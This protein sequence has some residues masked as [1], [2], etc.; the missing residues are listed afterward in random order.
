MTGYANFT[1]SNLKKC[2]AGTPFAA[3][4]S[5][6]H[7]LGKPHDLPKAAHLQTK[8]GAHFTTKMPVLG[9]APTINQHAD[10]PARPKP[11]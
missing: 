8:T 2:A 9:P 7:T 10:H 4:P 5:L 6:M 11:G 1:K 3:L